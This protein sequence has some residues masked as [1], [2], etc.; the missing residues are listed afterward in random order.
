MQSVKNVHNTFTKNRTILQFNQAWDVVF[1]G[2]LVED[3]NQFL[4]CNDVNST[5]R[6]LTVSNGAT[7]EGFIGITIE[8]NCVH[9]G[10]K[11]HNS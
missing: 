10:T 3:G 6:N 4:T 5:I 1:D 11:I 9:Y 8:L 2:G 7:I